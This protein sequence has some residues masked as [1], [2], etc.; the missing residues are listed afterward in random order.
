MGTSSNIRG[1]IQHCKDPVMNQSR[2]HA[3]HP[4]V[5]D[6]AQVCGISSCARNLASKEGFAEFCQGRILNLK[7]T[8]FFGIGIILLMALS[9]PPHFWGGELQ[10]PI[11]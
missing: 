6:V 11:G 2:I 7:K 4:R 10:W 5:L 3:W 1:I 8:N 9:S